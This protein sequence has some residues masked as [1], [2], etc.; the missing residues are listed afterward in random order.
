MS[1]KTDA[2]VREWEEQVRLGG[3]QALTHF[4]KLLLSGKE[5][6]ADDRQGLVD[7]LSYTEDHMVAVWEILQHVPE[8]LPLA[9]LLM[10]RRRV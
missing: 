9:Q 2:Q 7:L 3:L 6:T 4:R 5:L 10:K 1:E 8:R